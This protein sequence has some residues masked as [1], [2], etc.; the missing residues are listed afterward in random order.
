MKKILKL[1][2]VAT[3]CTLPTLVSAQGYVKMN[4]LYATVGVVNPS[5][6][7]VISPH[8]SV[9]MDIVFSPWRSWNDKHSQFGIFLGEYRY[10]F[11]QSTSGWYLSANAGLLGF[12]VHR[13]EF[14]SR[15]KI[16]GRQN[17]YGKGFGMAIGC[18]VGW[19]RHLGERWLMDIFLTVDRIGSWYNRYDADGDIVMNPQGHEH[20][21][22]SDPFNGSTE[23]APLKLGISFGYKIFKGKE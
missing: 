19:A 16:V 21:L 1:I 10:Y 6:E 20:Y 17:Q 9:A 7:F 3:F 22:K 12:D 11:K 2:I 13:F 5:V 15:G 23:V 18:G 14:F 4:A 8:S